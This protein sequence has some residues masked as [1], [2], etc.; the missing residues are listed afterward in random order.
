[1]GET[2]LFLCRGSLGS[3]SR[4]CSG[5]WA[6]EAGGDGW[7]LRPLVSRSSGLLHLFLSEKSKLGRPGP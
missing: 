6:G 2:A 7:G 4:G 3:L 5:K 1:M